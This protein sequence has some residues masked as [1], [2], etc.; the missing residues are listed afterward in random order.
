M[1]TPYVIS[2]KF[3]V[4]TVIHGRPSSPF[5]CITKPVPGVEMSAGQEIH[6]INPKTG[7]VTRGVITGEHWIIPWDSPRRGFI[8]LHYGV[9]PEVLRKALIATDPAFEKEWAMMVLILES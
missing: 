8:L 1:E 3:P 9:E 4:I 7:Q 2:D 5:F 6:C